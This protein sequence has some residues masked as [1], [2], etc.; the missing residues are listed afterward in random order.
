MSEM[1]Q[2]FRGGRT[3][4]ANPTSAQPSRCKPAVSRTFGPVLGPKTV[5]TSGF[6]ENVARK[7]LQ[8]AGLRKTEPENC[9]DQRVCRKRSQKTVATCGFDQNRFQELP[10]PVGLPKN[11][12]RKL[13]QPSGLRGEAC[14]GTRRQAAASNEGSPPPE[15]GDGDPS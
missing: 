15:T 9:C 7:L 1:Q 3:S 8:P 14:C 11:G 6:T 13:L 10:R 12:F 5:A 4:A 2:R